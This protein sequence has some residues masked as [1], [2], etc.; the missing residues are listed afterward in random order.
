[1]KSK[2]SPFSIAILSSVKL[3]KG[4]KKSPATITTVILNVQFLS[5]TKAVHC[6]HLSALYRFLQGSQFLNNFKIH[7]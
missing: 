5:S 1:M 2:A 6:Y 7:Y 3:F 4:K